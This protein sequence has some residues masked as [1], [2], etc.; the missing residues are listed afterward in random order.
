MASAPHFGCDV[1]IAH[2]ADPVPASRSGFVL[3]A[4]CLG[5]CLVF[6][7]SAVMN[8]AIAVVGRKLGLSAVEL[9]WIL[10]AELLPLAALT[11]VFGAIGDRFNPKIVF[12]SGIAVFG[13]ASLGSAVSTSALQLVAG[14]FLAGCGEAMVL[15][16]GLTIL[17]QA[18]PAERKAWAIGVWS[19]AA[20]V[21]SAV[22]PAAA[23]L[24]IDH[25]GWRGALWMQVPIAALALA[26]G[27]R[28][29]PVVRLGRAVP[30]DFAGAALSALGLVSFTWLLM[31]LTSSPREILQE[32][33]AAAG[34]VA[35]FAALV[36]VERRKGNRAM[37]PPAVFGG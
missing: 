7:S 2:S 14:R 9:Q 6:I 19:A 33:L 30:I 28:W 37:L 8:V 20:A 23:G 11:L 17:G 5:C 13:A 29:V 27:V 26:A 22:S 16:T 10:N 1:G 31:T 35:G 12:L 4:S 25:G 34:A 32:I 36:I 21:A 18:F 15:P 3:A 24:M